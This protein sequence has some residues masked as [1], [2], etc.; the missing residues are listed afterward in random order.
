VALAVGG[1]AVAS[2]EPKQLPA[3]EPAGP[4]PAAAAGVGLALVAA[5]GFGSFFVFMDEAADRDLLWALLVGRIT[6]SVILALV[7]LAARPSMAMDGPDLRALLA[8][9][10]LD[11]SANAL[12]AA[13]TTM[14][15]VSVVS[16]LG[17]L[18]PVT[19]ILLARFFLG[20]RLR[21]S[22]RGGAVAALAGV[23]LI[24]AG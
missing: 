24:S 4:R 22:Q 3:G 18:Y 14:G 20:E 7:A 15:L 17:S 6:S 19:T 23:A 11:V 12:F 2:F 5:L 16:V 1:V 13:G 21:P 10:F 8:I 9:G